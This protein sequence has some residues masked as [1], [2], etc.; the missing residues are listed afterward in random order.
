MPEFEAFTL[1]V[2]LN[3][4]Q[5]RIESLEVWEGRVFAGLADGTLMVLQEEPSN[6]TGPRWQVSQAIKGFG[7]RRILQLQVWRASKSCTSKH[8]QLLLTGISFFM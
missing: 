8:P 6:G 1:E 3:N 2:V 4:F 7:Q 5:K